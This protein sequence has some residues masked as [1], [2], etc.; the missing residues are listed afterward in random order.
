MAT[1]AFPFAAGRTDAAPERAAEPAPVDDF[2]GCHPL[3]MTWEEVW[4]YDG[5]IEYWDAPSSTAWILR[6]AGS[7]HEVAPSVLGEILTRIGLERGSR[8]RRFGAVFLME[9]DGA[10]RP[11]RVMAADQTV[12]LR[13]GR[14]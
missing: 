1:R 5:R 6:D 9:R 11:R 12:Y 8:I 7:V 4:R 14:R 10:G 2:P 3:R 13:P